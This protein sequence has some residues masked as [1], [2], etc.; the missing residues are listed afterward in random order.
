MAALPSLL[1]LHGYCAQDNPWVR[2]KPVPFT[3]Y[4]VYE[5]L[6]KSTLIH[7]YATKVVTQF[8]HLPSWGL[9]GH[10]Q[11]GMVSLHIRNFFWSANDAVTATAAAGR[12]VQSMGTPYHGVSGAGLALD[13]GDLFGVGCGENF[14]LTVDGANLWKS[15]LESSSIAATYYYTTVYKYTFLHPRYCNLAANLVLKWPND[16]VAEYDQSVLPGANHVD[17]FEGECHSPNMKW[18]AQTENLQRNAQMN[19]AAAR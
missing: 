14:D 7:Q 18:P 17:N 2:K 10:S 6:N 9:V 15:G 12:A 8:D 3:D 11:G 16:G 13:L 19:S 5:D 1:L 4:A